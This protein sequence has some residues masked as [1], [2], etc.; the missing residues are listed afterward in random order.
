MEDKLPAAMNARVCVRMASA[1]VR[2]SS[3]MWSLIGNFTRKFQEGETWEFRMKPT[4]GCSLL[5]AIM[6]SVY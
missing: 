3:F 2:V 4:K 6:R 5:G 1:H